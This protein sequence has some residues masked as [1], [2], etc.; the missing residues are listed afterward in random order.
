MRSGTTF[1]CIM[2]NHSG[3]AVALDEPMSPAQLISMRGVSRPDHVIRS[4]LKEQRRSL[5]EFGMAVSKHRRDGTVGNHFDGMRCGAATRHPDQQVGLL[6]FKVP[7]NFILA[8][9]HPAAF[10]AL[11][12]K[13]ASE[14]RC[15]ACVRNPVAILGSWES[16]GLA[17]RGRCEMAEQLC[18]ELQ[19]LLDATPD[20]ETRTILLLNWFF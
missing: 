13:L 12:R 19:R 20:S 4:L 18:P 2:L 8:I 17:Q 3:S 1:A 11:L 5:V 7:D 6:P 16:V 15:F 9:K 14:F 10:T